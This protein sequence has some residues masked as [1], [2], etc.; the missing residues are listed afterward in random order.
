MKIRKFNEGYDDDWD[1]E[2]P[3]KQDIF[4]KFND[5]IDPDDELSVEDG[6]CAVIVLTDYY[7][8]DDDDRGVNLTFTSWDEELEHPWFKE[9]YR[10][11]KEQ[12]KKN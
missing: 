4:N 8:H 11:F 7:S 10:L 9:Q 12:I 6:G 5:M 3:T 1:N 2:E